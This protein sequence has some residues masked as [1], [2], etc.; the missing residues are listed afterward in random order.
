MARTLSRVPTGN[1]VGRA[2][3]AAILRDAVEDAVAG[4]G[5]L[6]LLAGEPGI[7]KTRLAEEIAGHAATNG[8]RVL[9]GRCWEGGGA[10]AFWPWIQLIRGS[11]G[12]GTPDPVLAALEPELTYIAQLIP[13]LRSS[14]AQPQSVEESSAAVSLGEI[15]P[16]SGPER[17]RLFDAVTT[18]FKRL[19]AGSPL[20]MVLDDIHAADEDSLVLLRFLARELKQSCILVVATYRE[21]EVRQSAGHAALVAE[22]GREGTAVPLRGLNLEEVSDFVRRIGNISADHEMITSLR[23]ATGGNPFFLDEIARLMAAERAEGRPDRP[24]QGFAIPDSIRSAIRRRISPLTERTKSLLTVAS[25]IGNEFDLALLQ[26][27]SGIPAAQVL[28]SLGEAAAHAVIVEATGPEPYRFTHAI[29]A[30]ALRT[31][32][33]VTARA[34]VHQQIAAALERVHA[35]DLAPLA[36]LAHHCIQALPIGSAQKAVEYS[37]RGAARARS[38]LAFAEAVRLCGMT[39]RALDATGRP[40]EVERCQTLLAMGEAQAQGGS[41]DE[42]RQAFEQAAH[43]ARRLGR[44]SLLA[45]TALQTSAW[46][47][48]FFTLDRAL[49]AL[50][51]EALGALD[52]HDSALRASLMATLARERY[53]AGQR[54]SG[55]ELSDQAVAMARRFGERCALLSALWI[56]NQIRWGPEDVE[57][58]LASAT[59]IATLAESVGD[60]QRALRAREMRFTALLEIG[61]IA[62]AEAETRVYAV[63][64]RR[65]GE[66]FGI[67]ERFDAAL[68]LFKGDF[69]HAEQQAQELSQH[70]QRRQDPALLVC[71]HVLTI[72]LRDEQG[73]LE[74]TYIAQTVSDMAQSPALA[75]QYRLNMAFVNIM[76]GRRAE[77]QAEVDSLVRD[78]CAAV[79]R[80]WNWLDNMRGLSILCLALRDAQHAAIVYGLMLPYAERNITTGWGEVARGSAAMYLGVLAGLLGRPDDATAHLERALSFNARMGA[81]PSLARTQFE[82]ARLTLKRDDQSA[83][84]ER[85]LELLRLAH[86]TASELGMTPLEQRAAKL[87]EKLGQSTDMRGAALPDTGT[88]RKIAAAAMADPSSLRAHVEPGGTLTMLF[89]DV[90]N[91]TTLFDTL[92]DLRA[93]EILDAHNAIVR[94]HVALQKGFEVK[95]TGDGFLLVFSSARRALLCAIGIQRGLAAYSRQEGHTPVRVRIGL[96]VGEPITLSADLSGTAVIVAARI[97]SIAQGGEIL[98]SSTLRELTES[99]GDLRFADAG[100]VELK[101]LSGTRRVYRAVW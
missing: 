50:V 65:A 37:R 101:G 17:F 89:S 48:T 11:R 6:V 4:R 30:E 25:V 98:V 31:E 7:G 49:I 22:I 16:R 93:Q 83:G 46:F 66:Q 8:A 91:S 5:R 42:A 85:A 10:P 71:A 94:E 53:W 68:A 41:L 75:V 18:V 97:A 55:L 57:R 64:A 54:E 34:Q 14:R 27:A 47:E 43:V 33:G 81:R 35:N 24:V 74:P 1:F 73:R 67:V 51:E 39:L 86:A 61:D 60:Y 12:S 96:H 32:L 36:K 90:E 56:A 19:A 78:Q 79:P 100:E 13:E 77:A 95:S 58:R 23:R 26:E 82:Y 40:D 44:A 45:E 59:E 2:R 80:D 28:A 52:P 21:L 63:L 87:L 38:Q 29:I 9:W 70:A 88:I 99:A 15:S 20:M 3:E 84:R 76:S 72:A 62:G 69:A 92:G